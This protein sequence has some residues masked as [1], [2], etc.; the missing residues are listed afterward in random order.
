MVREITR[1]ELVAKIE[2]S[3]NGHPAL[4][5]QPLTDARPS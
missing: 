4:M 5:R 1:D 2:T 3:V